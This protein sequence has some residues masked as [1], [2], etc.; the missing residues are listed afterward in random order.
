MTARALS[1]E[2]VAA[3]RLGSHHLADPLPASRLVE[4][5]RDSGGIQ[6]QLANAAQLSIRARTRGLTPDM[7]DRA[8]SGERSLVKVWT[9]RHTVHIIPTGDLPVYVSAL[10]G[11]LARIS[12]GWYESAGLTTEV[13]RGILD[14][15]LEALEGG[16]LTRRELADVVE[17]TI[18]S[19]HRRWV[20]GSWGGVLKQGFLDGEL[21]FGPSQGQNVTFM[22]RDQVLR[23]WDP[24]PRDEAMAILMRRH[25]HAYGP[26]RLQDFVAWTASTVRECRPAWDSIAG[27]TAEVEHGGR[28]CSMLAEDL[29]MAESIGPGDPTVNLLGHFDT[30]LLGHKER[31]Q[32]MDAPHVKRVSGKAGWV[33][34]VVLVDG[35][36]V[37][38]WS[39]ERRGG[40]V[41]VV[42]APFGRLAAGVRPAVRRE[43]A[44]L[45]RFWG[46]PC[47]VTYGK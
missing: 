2:Q 3:F 14:A 47:E 13:R 11:T 44:D 18:G 20:E 23:E 31:T 5:V 46:V 28:T 7:V 33:R 16:P 26:A 32:V 36:A 35:R 42:V 45:R 43:V 34:P 15:V 39:Q 21:V 17:P 37:A 29:E 8:L 6:A 25:L 41:R 12:Q 10:G 27:E 19:R 30:F 40:R 1:R 4:A 9:M 22:R 24:P 38:T